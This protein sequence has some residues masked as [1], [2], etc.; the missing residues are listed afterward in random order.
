MPENSTFTQIGE[1]FEKHQFFAVVSHVRPDG[2]AIGSIL[3]LGHAL[4]QK[5]KSV[6]YL[7]NDGCPE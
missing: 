1:A 5:G 3:A 6:R 4:E 7:N 2:D